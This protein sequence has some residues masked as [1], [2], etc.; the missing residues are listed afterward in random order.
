MY[1]VLLEFQ[2][3]ETHRWKYVNGEWLAGGKAEPQGK[4]TI[5]ED[6]AQD[7]K[8]KGHRLRQLFEAQ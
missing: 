5:E 7:N 2:Q 8:L 6:K 1:T 3:I 4:V